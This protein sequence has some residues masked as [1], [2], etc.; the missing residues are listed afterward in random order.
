MAHISVSEAAD[1]YPLS[2]K[3]IRYLVAEGMVKGRKV[4]N[5]WAVD[6]TSL[7]WYLV[8]HRPPTGRPPKESRKKIQKRD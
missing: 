3:H 1:R 5:S 6:E 8:N 4:G 2:A 7:K